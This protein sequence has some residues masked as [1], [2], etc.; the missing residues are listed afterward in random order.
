MINEFSKDKKKFLA[1]KQMH[2]TN[3]INF[4]VYKNCNYNILEK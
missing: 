1:V 3:D 4:K 2:L